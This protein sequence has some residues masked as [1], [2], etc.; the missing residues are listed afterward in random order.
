MRQLHLWGMVFNLYSYFETMINDTTFDG[1]HSSDRNSG[2]WV[3][4]KRQMRRR[5][6]HRN[7]KNTEEPYAPT[8]S[9]TPFSEKGSTKGGKSEGPEKIELPW[10]CESRMKAALRTGA[11]SR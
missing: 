3:G 4:S 11:L 1:Y 8:K 2:F 9:D 10:P 7:G 6:P 5:L